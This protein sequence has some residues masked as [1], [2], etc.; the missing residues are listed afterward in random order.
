MN[1]KR[2][3]SVNFSIPIG[4]LDKLDETCGGEGKRS[5]YITN[6]LKKALNMN[7]SNNT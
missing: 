6:L 2:R 1:P 3:V 4:V 7:N 5:A